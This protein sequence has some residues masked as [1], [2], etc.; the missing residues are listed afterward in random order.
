MKNDH[1]VDRKIVVPF[2]SIGTPDG[3][4]AVKAIDREL[5]DKHMCYSRTFFP[6]EVTAHRRKDLPRGVNVTLVP[7]NRRFDLA[8]WYLAV[9]DDGV[10]PS[11]RGSILIP[12]F[13]F[14]DGVTAAPGA[15]LLLR[16]SLRLSGYRSL[17]GK[18]MLKDDVIRVSSLG[19]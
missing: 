7:G 11:R 3:V 9:T 19:L 15:H 14:D 8:G 13:L 5:S 17:H 2:I 1:T 18:P 4:D 6:C 12:D 10:D 16:A